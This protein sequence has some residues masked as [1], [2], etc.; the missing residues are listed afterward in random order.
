MVIKHVFNFKNNIIDK[1]FDI[2]DMHL[3]YLYGFEK[4]IKLKFKVRQSLQNKH[5]FNLVSAN[6][7]NNKKVSYI[8]N[9]IDENQLLLARRDAIK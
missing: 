6:M 9:N 3:Y 8:F 4:H 2:I 1:D 5:S 7:D